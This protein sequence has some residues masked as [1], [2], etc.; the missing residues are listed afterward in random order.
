MVDRPLPL[1]TIITAFNTLN[2]DV[3]VARRTQLG[4]SARLDEQIR[5][6]KRLESQM[7]QV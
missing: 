5:I 3:H 6:C 2:Y 1:G 7:V 4:D